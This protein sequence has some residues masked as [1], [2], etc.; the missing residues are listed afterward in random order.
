MVNVENLEEG[1]ED[2]S[3]I[4]DV[5]NPINLDNSEEELSQNVSVATTRNNEDENGSNIN[6]NENINEN[7]KELVSKDVTCIDIEQEKGNRS[8]SLDN[9]SETSKILQ[10][11]LSS[12]LQVVEAAKQQN[13]EEN[14]FDDRPSTCIPIITIDYVTEPD[15]HAKA[16]REPEQKRYRN[17]ITGIALQSMRQNM[18]SLSVPRRSQTS[19]HSEA[20]KP[21]ILG[22][23]P[24]FMKQQIRKSL[25]VKRIQYLMEKKQR[26]NRKREKRRKQRSMEK[27]VEADRMRVAHESAIT[28]RN[29]SVAWT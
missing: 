16:N 12:F 8:V 10:P 3:D 27:W 25:G 13:S 11:K 22:K 26:K 23:H 24:A 17:P 9:T 28:K 18:Q 15:V 19:K 2:E 1:K 21:E 4:I 7:E 29:S 6:V 20:A 5:D 14:R